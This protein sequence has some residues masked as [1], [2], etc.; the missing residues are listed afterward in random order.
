[1]EANETRQSEDEHCGDIPATNNQIIRYGNHKLL[2]IYGYASPDVVA[3]I[4]VLILRQDE[5]LIG[6]LG[7]SLQP[8]EEIARS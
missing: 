6:N 1:M 8:C 7:E 3:S 4:V 5:Q 2:L